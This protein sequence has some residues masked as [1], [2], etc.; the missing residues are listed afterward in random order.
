M[1]DL[2]EQ[3]DSLPEKVQEEI[4]KFN[5]IEA[6]DHSDCQYFLEKLMPLGYTF[7]CGLDGEPYDLRKINN[8]QHCA[9]CGEE[10]NELYQCDRCGRLISG[11]CPTSYNQFTQ[12]DYNCC[13]D[14][15]E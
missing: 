14:C 1:K 5:S 11:C 3:F 10:A 12:I 7:S 9:R 2:F 6:R 8:M 13:K 4:N 15:I